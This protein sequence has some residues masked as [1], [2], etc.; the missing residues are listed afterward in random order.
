MNFHVKKQTY[1]TSLSVV[2]NKNGEECIDKRI[3]YF[4]VE[5]FI[6]IYVFI[7][8]FIYLFLGEG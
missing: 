7:Y 6:L 5:L 8:I 1:L 3:W 2:S 4:E